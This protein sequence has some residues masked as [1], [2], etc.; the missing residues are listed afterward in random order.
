MNA[1]K[2][3]LSTAAILLT[4][5]A[6]V[7]A[8]AAYAEDRDHKE[9]LKT[10]SKKADSRGHEDARQGDSKELLQGV[11]H[12]VTLSNL[13]NGS[14]TEIEIE[15]G[16]ANRND[17]RQTNNCGEE[18]KG[19]SSCIINVVFMPKTP[20]PKTA[21]ME[22]HTSGGKQVVYLSGTGV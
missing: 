4:A 18:L 15:I 5:G 16:G 21:T 7:A 14:L 17:F 11:P 2:I 19:K 1:K 3:F 13:S 8:N 20:G 6:Y 9:G 12:P 10:A 22:V